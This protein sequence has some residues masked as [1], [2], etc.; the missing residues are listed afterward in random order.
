MKLTES[1]KAKV[2]KFV[3][4]LQSIKLNE[5]DET[6]YAQKFR[7]WVTNLGLQIDLSGKQLDVTKNGQT[8]LRKTTNSFFRSAHLDSFANQIA[9]K[10]GVENDFSTTSDQATEIDASALDPKLAELGQILAD[11]CKLSK[12]SK[13]KED[14]T[15]RMVMKVVDVQLSRF[16]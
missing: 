3:K 8:I 2:I 9:K 12:A 13:F 14:T 7:N 15:R 11:L 6:S 5:S 10:L 16:L 1:Q 4:S